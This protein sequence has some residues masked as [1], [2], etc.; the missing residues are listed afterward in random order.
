MVTDVL[1]DRVVEK[2]TEEGVALQAGAT[3]LQTESGEDML[4]PT[5][6]SYTS[7]AL[8]AQGGSIGE[9]DPAF[10]QSTLTTYKYAAI[11]DVSSELAEDNGVGNFN[12]LTF[13]TKK[14]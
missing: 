11:T 5:V 12:V 7:G 3:L 13:V 9:S 6:T 8:V 1:Y 14:G 4:I 10:G 2:F